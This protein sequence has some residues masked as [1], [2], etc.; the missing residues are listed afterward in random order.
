MTDFFKELEQIQLSLRKIEKDT[1]ILQENYNERLT[2]VNP[3]DRK[4][5]YLNLLIKKLTQVSSADF[6]T[7]KIHLHHITS[8][9]RNVNNVYS[10]L[11]QE[12]EKLAAEVD[13]TSREVKTKLEAI[14]KNDPNSMRKLIVNPLIAHLT[15]FSER[16]AD[17]GPTSRTEDKKKCSFDTG[18]RFHSRNGKVPRNSI[19]V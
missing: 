17:A 2:A 8:I 3:S 7:S 12:C 18:A 10:G 4:S 11:G 6:G 13:R 19:T 16:K 14:A 15:C 1:D 5:N 9:Q